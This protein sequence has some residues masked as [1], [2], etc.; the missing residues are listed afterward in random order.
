MVGNCYVK[1]GQSGKLERPRERAGKG[2]PR[3]LCFSRG[4]HTESLGFATEAFRTALE[5]SREPQK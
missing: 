5:V 2:V 1:S 3:E 4:T